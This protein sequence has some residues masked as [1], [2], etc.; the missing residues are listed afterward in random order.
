MRQ[1]GRRQKGIVYSGMLTCL[2][3]TQEHD[4]SKEIP[5]GDRYRERRRVGFQ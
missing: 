1:L 2:W 3:I 5:A 4:I